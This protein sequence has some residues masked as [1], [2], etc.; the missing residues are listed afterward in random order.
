MI[1]LGMSSS[2]AVIVRVVKLYRVQNRR[3]FGH[4]R[5]VAAGEVIESLAGTETFTL[6]E[7][8]WQ[9]SIQCFWQE[10]AEAGTK[11]RQRTE[12]QR[13]QWQEIV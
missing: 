10:Q 2:A 4:I 6:V 12:H 8:R 11:Q 9:R 1:T 13:R 3:R 7:C 5:L